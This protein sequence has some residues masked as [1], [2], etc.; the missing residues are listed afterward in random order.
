LRLS[1]WARICRCP[2][3][4]ATLSA[5]IRTLVGEAGCLLHAVHNAAVHT[6]TRRGDRVEAVDLAASVAG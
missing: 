5:H 1:A 6:A 2:T 3:C 4:A